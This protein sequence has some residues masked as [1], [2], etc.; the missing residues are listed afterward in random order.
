MEI[1]FEPQ[2]MIDKAGNIRR[3]RR[4]REVRANQAFPNAE[5]QKECPGKQIL[6][7]PIWQ[8]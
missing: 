3:K 1:V 7:L 2:G 8:M 4:I 6:H 5:Q